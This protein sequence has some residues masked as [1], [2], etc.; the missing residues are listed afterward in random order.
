MMLL[1]S[2]EDIIHACTHLIK[3]P[4]LLCHSKN[5]LNVVVTQSVYQLRNGGVVLQKLTEMKDTLTFPVV[6][7]PVCLSSILL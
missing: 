4:E 3:I 1:Q 2:G 7:L 6:C 5:G